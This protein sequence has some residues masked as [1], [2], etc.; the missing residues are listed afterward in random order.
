[1]KALCTGIEE[2]LSKINFK[3]K[4]LLLE[5]CG[6]VDGKVVD[7]QIN[8]IIAN[9]YNKGAFHVLKNTYKLTSLALK[10]I[11][12]IKKGE[13]I[14]EIENEV[15]SKKL[16]ENHEKEKNIEIIK[17]LLELD[18]NKLEGEKLI[19]FEQ[20]VIETIGKSLNK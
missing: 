11:D 4:I 13:N 10:K 9:C 12:V 7:I 8:K 15:I 2:E 5:I 20:R 14:L 6:V 16:V 1:M 18:F 19:Q 3:D 17:F